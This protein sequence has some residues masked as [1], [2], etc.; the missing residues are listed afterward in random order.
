MK[1]ERDPR[2]EIRPVQLETVAVVI[3]VQC[4][5]RKAGLCVGEDV[6][7]KERVC[8]CKACRR[9]G[10]GRPTSMRGIRCGLVREAGRRVEKDTGRGNERW[11]RLVVF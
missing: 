11:V 6:E 8:G 10:C 9:D 1:T 2:R 3:H 7:E 4:G 5:N